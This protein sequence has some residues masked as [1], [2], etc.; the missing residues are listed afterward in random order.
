[1]AVDGGVRVVAEHL[2]ERGGQVLRVAG[3]AAAAGTHQG[4]IAVGGG[5]ETVC[6]SLPM[7]SRVSVERMNQ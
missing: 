4:A 7:T 3:G 6:S 2:R 5:G 1:V